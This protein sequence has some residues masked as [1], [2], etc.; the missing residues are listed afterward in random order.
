[1]ELCLI[2][3][4]I[5]KTQTQL[6]IVLLLLCFTMYGQGNIGIGTTSP[7]ATALLELHSFNK[8]ILIPRTKTS[9]R[10][11]IVDPADGLL[12]YDVNTESFW[13]Y[14]GS[15]WQELNRSDAFINDGGLIYNNDDLVNNVLLFGRDQLPAAGPADTFLVYHG[16][17]GAFRSG[18]SASTHWAVD[19]LGYFSFGAGQGIKASGTSSAAL[20]QSTRAEGD[21]SFAAGSAAVA[22]GFSSIAIGDQNL[23]SGYGSTSFGYKTDALGQWSTSMG[24]LTEASGGSSTAMGSQTKAIGGHSTAMGIQTEAIGSYST[25]MGRTTKAESRTSVAMGR[26]NVGGGNPGIWQDGDPLFEIGNGLDASNLHNAMTVLKNGKTG[27]G[28]SS[29]DTNLSVVGV[30]RAAFSE[31]ESNYIEMAHGGSNAYINAGGTGNLDFRHGGNTHMTLSSSGRVGIGTTS[32]NTDFSVIG[33]VRSAISSNENEF[34]EI[35][36]G[37]DNGFINTVGDGNL[38]FRHDNNTQMSLTDQGDLEVMGSVRVGVMGGSASSGV[39][40]FDTSSNEF[41]GYDGNQWKSLNHS[42]LLR[43]PTDGDTKIE[44]TADDKLVF[45]IDSTTFITI[46]YRSFDL[47]IGDRNVFLGESAGRGS[48]SWVDPTGSQNVAIGSYAL[49]SNQG[50]SGSTAVGYHAMRF[51]DNRE[52]GV[53]TFNTALGYEALR[54]VPN[55]SLNTG[56]SNTAIGHQSLKDNRDGNY[57]V[58]VGFEA[59]EMNEY[60]SNNTAVGRNA[61]TNNTD[62]D[63]NTALGSNALVNNTTGI[64]NTALGQNALYS[65]TTGSNNVSIGH[66]ALNSITDQDEL[67]AVGAESLYHNHAERATAVG[68]QA[69]MFHDGTNGFQ[70]NTAIGHQA[71]KGVNGGGS[72][73]I[74]NTAVGDLAMTTNSQGSRNTALGSSALHDNPG[75]ADNTALGYRTLHANYAGENTAVGSYSMEINESGTVNT[76]MGFNALR[77]NFAGDKNVAAGAYAMQLNSNGSENVG[78]GY[79]A[80]RSNTLGHRNIA[81]GT[82]ALEDN[83]IG[84]DNVSIGYQ[85]LLENTIGNKIV[86]VGANALRTNR[87]Q[88]RTT[89]IGYGAMEFANPNTAG[90][91][92]YNTAIGY[93]A[94]RGGAPNT[95][96]SGRFNTAVGDRAMFNSTLATGNTAIGRNAMYYNVSGNNNTACGLGALRDN[97][98]GHNNTAL[99]YNAFFTNGLL[100]NTIAIGYSAGGQSNSSNRT[101]IGNTSMSWI[102]GEVSWST[103]SDQRIK[104]NVQEDVPGVDFINRLRPVTYNLDIH[105]QNSMTLGDKEIGDWEGK[106][107]IEDI[108][109]TGFIAQEVEA[110]AR[111]SNYEFSGVHRADDEV[112]LYSLSYSQFTVPLVK[113][114]QELSTENELLKQQVQLLLERVV[115]MEE[116]LESLKKD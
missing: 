99:G 74:H 13:Y 111:A 54:G 27:I 81:I 40:Q 71:L 31:A 80:M 96:N 97:A 87:A 59:M 10:L 86:A 58:A 95:N 25:A 12:I 75:G 68:F 88:S 28:T 72:I 45:D 70:Y 20:G 39:V 104:E 112:G 64:A 49:H 42:E 61:L 47:E 35:F 69:L 6:T 82:K 92:T 30:S 63:E 52:N 83:S 91:E 18:R 108:K 24:H 62:G 48:L 17:R 113:A 8:G 115:E 94:Y 2:K 98:T 67:V 43:D 60:G 21:R 44:A 76:A 38:D 9:N 79:F 73:G 36:H 33:K 15:E 66:D 4:Q 41:V 29:P 1:M 116:V 102:G 23:S 107:D 110:A 11:D 14:D 32:P 109:M 77:S 51:A 78:M 106:Y 101:E 50:N 55:A 22:S 34:T 57:N 100:S 65:V 84:A 89:A 105:K 56:N 5:M 53:F 103:Y 3:R 26:F 93:E 85:S 16:P 19:S 90:L 46:D 114:V 7:E 37:G